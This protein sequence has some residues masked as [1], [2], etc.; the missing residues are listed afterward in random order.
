MYVGITRAQRSLHL[1]Y[2]RR[3]GGCY[4]FIPGEP[5]RFIAE[6]GKEDI[7]SPA[8]NGRRAGQGGRQRPARRAEGHA[9]R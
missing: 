1:S 5:S 9:G 6:M 2:C 4:E 7:P 8:A 3:R